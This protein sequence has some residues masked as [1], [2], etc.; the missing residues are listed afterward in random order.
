MANK[1]RHFCRHPGCN[2]ITDQLYCAAHAGDAQKVDRRA[3]AAE[4][5]YDAAWHR[6]AARY[7]AQPEHRLCA[8]RISP[9]CRLYAECVDHIVPLAGPGDPKRFALDNLQPS[10]LACNT[11]KGRRIIRGSFRMDD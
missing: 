11:L 3:G 9:R 1:S 4:R 7:L 2:V 8:L 6:F 10:C 5:G